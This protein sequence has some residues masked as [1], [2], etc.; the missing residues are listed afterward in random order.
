M[1]INTSIAHW[2]GLVAML[3]LAVLLVRDIVPGWRTGNLP[4]RGVDIRRATM[5]VRY[6][7]LM[8]TR[9]VMMAATLALMAFIG[10]RL[11]GWLPV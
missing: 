9:I 8:I 4:S 5:P 7:T 2:L 11:L 1:D 6:W 3:V 10:M